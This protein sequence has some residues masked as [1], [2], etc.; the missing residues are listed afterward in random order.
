MKNPVIKYLDFINHNNYENS[1]FVH[2]NGFYVGN[3]P[4]DLSNEIDLLYE[5]IHNL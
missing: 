2:E 1:N 3:Y 5:I 4:K